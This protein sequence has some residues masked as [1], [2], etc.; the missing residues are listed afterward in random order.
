MIFFL[1][2][3]VLLWTLVIVRPTTT[4]TAT[5]T[6][7][8]TATTTVHNRASPIRDRNVF[9][10]VHHVLA[11]HASKRPA[12][13][14]VGIDKLVN[15]DRISAVISLLSAATTEMLVALLLRRRRRCTVVLLNDL[16]G[17]LTEGV[18][19]ELEALALL[20]HVT[21]RLPLFFC[22]LDVRGTAARIM[23]AAVAVGVVCSLL[24]LLLLLLLVVVVVTVVITVAPLLIPPPTSAPGAP[25]AAWPV[26]WVALAKER[27]AVHR[28]PHRFVKLRRHVV[29]RPRK[30]RALVQR[31]VAV[32]LVC[33]VR[34]AT[35]TATSVGV[36]RGARRRA[37]KPTACLLCLAQH[38]IRRIDFAH[39]ALLPRADN[40]WM[41]RLGELE[42]ALADL[43]ERLPCGEPKR[44]VGACYVCGRGASAKLR[45]DCE[46]CHLPQ[47]AVYSAHLLHVLLR[48]KFLCLLTR[49]I[50]EIKKERKKKRKTTRMTA[51]RRKYSFIIDGQ[52][53]I[54]CLRRACMMM[55]IVR[56][57]FHHLRNCF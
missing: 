2:E 17:L 20:V 26:G 44:A 18:C 19:D 8:A 15:K 35:A 24:L 7:A 9:F 57:S 4:T 40:V 33:V 14:L 1:L 12:H 39:F 49:K 31:A 28:L 48:N 47:T 36:G 50:I 32:R 11:E 27:L 56:K 23:T 52:K 30:P 22:P 46:G 53:K 3:L 51:E 55:T 10:V 41:V 34:T 37:A 21:K 54:E 45:K 29:K 16:A 5:A 6:T 43:C 38:V 25:S 42:I 13:H